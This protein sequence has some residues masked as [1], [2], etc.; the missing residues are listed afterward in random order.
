[1]LNRR[2]V[3]L[4]SAA[5]P[6]ALSIPNIATAVPSGRWYAVCGNQEFSYPIWA[7]STKEAALYFAEDHDETLGADC[8]ECGE[9]ECREHLDPKDWKEPKANVEVSAPDTWAGIGPEKE[10]TNIEWM[11]AGYNVPCESCN[12][13]EPDECYLFDGEAVCVECLELLKGAKL[14]KI[15]GNEIPVGL[16]EPR[17]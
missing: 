14:D 10:P 9:I 6:V 3:L 4:S 16:F 13:G 8:P 1:M 12:V 5:V 17:L 2:E 11:Q 15:I 7:R